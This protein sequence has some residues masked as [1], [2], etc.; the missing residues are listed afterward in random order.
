MKSLL[1]PGQCPSLCSRHDSLQLTCCRSAHIKAI[2]ERH[3]AE[4]AAMVQAE[5]GLKLAWTPD[6]DVFLASKV[7][8]PML[9]DCTNSPSSGPN[10][11]CP[12]SHL[13]ICCRQ[14]Q[15][16]IKLH[17]FDL[18]C[19]SQGISYFSAMGTSGPVDCLPGH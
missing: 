11:S 9:A 4:Q 1:T 16:H 2:I 14:M 3:L 12:I 7:T 17:E 10:D 15:A 13:D 18:G 19:T 6:A 5:H 8:A